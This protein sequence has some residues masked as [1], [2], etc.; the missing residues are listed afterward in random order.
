ME[1]KKLKSGAIAS[2]PRVTGE[3]DPD[4]PKHWRWG[5]NWEEKIDGQWRNRSFGC[6]PVGT[7]PM[8]QSMQKSDVSL[9]EIIDFIRRS[10]RKV[11]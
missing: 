6:V 7:I 11:Q 3:R 5:F 2:Y 8:I 4:N 10:K 9:Q 1:N